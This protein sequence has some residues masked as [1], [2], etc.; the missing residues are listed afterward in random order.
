MDIKPK[1]DIPTLPRLKVVSSP[2]IPKLEVATSPVIPKVEMPATSLAS[3]VEMAALPVV[4]KMPVFSPEVA[5]YLARV[6][7]MMWSQQSLW[8]GGA[9]VASGTN[10]PY[11]NYGQ[12]MA[13]LYWQQYTHMTQR[14]GQEEQA[15][16]PHATENKYAQREMQQNLEMTPPDSEMEDEGKED[17]KE[18]DKPFHCG[19]PKCN[20]ETNRRNNLKRHMMTMHERLNAPHFC[21]GVTFFR[22]ADMRLH[23][24]E[25]HSDG[26]T[27][28]WPGCGKGFVRKALLDRHV[29]IHTG[30]KPFTCSVCQY[31]TSHKSNL[32][33]HVKIHLKFYASPS[34]R[35]H[36]SHPAYDFSRFPSPSTTSPTWEQPSPPLPDST[37]DQHSRTQSYL[38]SPD[39]MGFGVPFSPVDLANITPLNLSPVKKDNNQRDMMDNNQRDVM[40]LWWNSQRTPGMDLP[41]S[42][43]PFTPP[44]NLPPT[45]T[46]TPAKEENDQT[47]NHPISHGIA[48]ILGDTQY[49]PKKLRVAKKH[50]END[51]SNQSID[52]ADQS[53]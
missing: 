30:E 29:K 46:D 38:F 44:S 33:R 14:Y 53:L 3:K 9:N 43:R 37:T 12:D 51:D 18:A 50:S 47:S 36:A 2:L 4:P 11:Y 35:H 21:C 26:Y 6:H 13:A 15:K 39:K 27:C 22:K 32:D 45:P 16:Y 40:D 25:S 49:V 7:A 20:Y 24:K 34:K 31:G 42:P 48:A 19:F 1:L 52:L 41:F 28:S 23:T 5:A 8:N 10:V 17:G